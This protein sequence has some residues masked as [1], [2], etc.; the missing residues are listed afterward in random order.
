MWRSQ[1]DL[2][3]AAV[4]KATAPDTVEAGGTGGQGPTDRSRAG[5]VSPGETGGACATSGPVQCSEPGVGA[6]EPQ[7]GGARAAA[8]A[9]TD[10]AET[11]LRLL[12]TG[13]AAAPCP[14]ISPPVGLGTDPLRPLSLC[15]SVSLALWLSQVCSSM[16]EALWHW[17]KQ[18]QRAVEVSRRRQ[19]INCCDSSTLHCAN[20]TP[21]SRGWARHTSSLTPLWCVCLSHISLSHR[22]LTIPWC[23]GGCRV[24]V[25]AHSHPVM[26]LAPTAARFCS[27]TGGLLLLERRAQWHRDRGR[28]SLRDL[29]RRAAAARG[30]CA[31]AVR[32]SL[33]RAVRR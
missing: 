18:P 13:A 25:A 4:G 33:P 28:E 9:A 22:H 20:C 30:W 11:R 31:V 10:S 5:G 12:W 32:P 27:R 29:H 7:G 23:A 21:A 16:E 1:P 17:M 26:A 14:Y 24:Q 15:L 6:E 19:R 8:H 3:A 2:A